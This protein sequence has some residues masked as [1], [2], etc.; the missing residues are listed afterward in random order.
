M[1]SNPEC[2]EVGVPLEVLLEKEGGKA[3]GKEGASSISC[4]ALFCLPEI[5]FL[6]CRFS[7]LVLFST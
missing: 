1:S 6:P 7:R 5:F 2:R 4:D 3:D